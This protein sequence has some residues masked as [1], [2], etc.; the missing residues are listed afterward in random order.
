MARLRGGID[1]LPVGQDR[2]LFC[3]MA[4]SWRDEPDATVPMRF[5][6]PAHEGMHPFPRR[7]PAFKGF[8]WVGWR[9]FQGSE[10]TLGVG[11][12]IADRGTAE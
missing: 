6:V 7:L 12:V 5:V 4:F 1:C 11:V 9:V 10:Q 2:Q 3:A 8:G